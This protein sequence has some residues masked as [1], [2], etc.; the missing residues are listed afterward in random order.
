MVNGMPD[1]SEKENIG[2]FANNAPLAGSQMSKDAPR[3]A[4]S[5]IS[6]Q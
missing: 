6:S 4:G 3:N 1:A 2:Q 5:K